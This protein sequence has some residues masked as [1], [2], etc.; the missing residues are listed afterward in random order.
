MQVLADNTT[1]DVST[2]KH[3]YVPKAPNDTTKFLRGDATWAVPTA[4]ASPLR[5]YIWGLTMSNAAD[6]ANDITVAAGIATSESH[7]ELITLSASIT[8]R[9]DAGWA[10]GDNQGGLN[11]GAEA[12]NTWYEVHLIK[13]TDTGVVDVMFTT[14]ANRATLPANYDKQR[15]IGWIRNDSGGAILAFTQVDDYFTLT[16]P[17]NDVSATATASST[18]RTITAPP[19]SIARMRAS[20]LGN[21]SVNA[22]NAVVFR[23]LVETDT[24]PTTTNGYNSI[25]SG[26]FAVQ[27][28]CHLDLRVNSSSQIADRAITATGSMAYDISTYGWIDHRRRLSAT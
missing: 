10:V 5:G 13:R 3:G 20:C 18:S 26:D 28:A 21:T 1:Q 9:L 4:S 19:S 16:T 2:T 6:A 11:T 12:N 27:G 15:R 22:A 23:E 17:Q 25:G 8:K 7:D 24:A 14:T